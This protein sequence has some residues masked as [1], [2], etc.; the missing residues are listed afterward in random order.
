[1]LLLRQHESVRFLLRCTEKES[2]RWPILAKVV[3]STERGAKF[4][5]L[6]SFLFSFVFCSD[7]A[8]GRYFCSEHSYRVLVKKFTLLHVY[9]LGHFDQ[10]NRQENYIHLLS[11][12]YCLGAVTSFC[13]VLLSLLFQISCILKTLPMRSRWSQVIRT[14]TA[15]T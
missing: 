4:T 5:M 2:L 9:Q 12:H 14:S 15:A 8:R 13:L 7:A 6:L 11:L 3:F 10:S 1:M